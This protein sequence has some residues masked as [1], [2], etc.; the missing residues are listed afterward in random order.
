M[1]RDPRIR[2]VQQWGKQ[3]HWSWGGFRKTVRLTRVSEQARLGLGWYLQE[4]QKEG[5]V[6]KI[7]HTLG[8]RGNVN[9]HGESEMTAFILSDHNDIKLKTNSKRNDR[10]YRTL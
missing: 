2:F 7:D 1:N 9:K 5:A 3:L 4:V 8:H 6:S 10:E